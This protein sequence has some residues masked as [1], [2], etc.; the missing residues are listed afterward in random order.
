[1]STTVR[2]LLPEKL[3]DFY[4]SFSKKY[5]WY[6]T[7]LV[8]I[9][10]VSA[11]FRL[12]V[13]YELQH[14]IDSVAENPKAPMIA[15]LIYFLFHKT[16]HHVVHFLQKLLG[17]FYKPRILQDVTETVY[18]QVMRH[19]LQW[20]DVNRSGE[21]SAKIQDFQDS[22][23]GLVN[24]AFYALS[25][26]FIVAL[27]LV[28]LS[29]VSTHATVVLLVFTIIY[30]PIITFFV[31]KQMN[32]E[33]K[34]AIVRQEAFGTINDSISNVFCIKT[35]GRFSWEFDLKL[36]PIL[37]KW[38]L[39]ERKSRQYHAY[40]VDITDTILVIAMGIVQFT[41]I[42]HLYR[43]GLLTAGQFAF[44]AVVTLQLHRELSEL[45]DDVIF[46][47]NPKLAALKAAYSFIRLDSDE[48][49]VGLKSLPEIQGKI[50]YRNVYF[51]YD[52]E[53]MVL[54]NLSITIMPGEKIGIVGPSGA[55]KSTFIKSLLKYFPVSKGNIFIDDI[56]ISGI[57]QESI[58]EHIALIPQ[59]IP[60]FH[61]SILENIRIVNPNSSTEEIE[62][63]CKK[64]YIHNEIM[65]MPNQYNTIVGERGVRLSG[66]QR[67]RLA[68][69]R[70]LLKRA[71]I[72]IL[73]EATSALD[74]PTERLIQDSLN[75]I[76][77]ETSATTLMIAHRLSTL[78]KMDRVIVFQNGNIVQD[79]PHDV[80]IS[81]SNGLYKKLW[82]SQN[83]K[84]LTL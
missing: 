68:M 39:Y 67:Q 6:L 65:A 75:A 48:K 9:A 37:K 63:A 11:L 73:D 77:R 66:G 40:Y 15:L 22:L 21:I 24:G 72:L 52:H 20:F 64:A 43:N 61:R 10:L 49:E 33:N 28:F 47:C 56:P 3:S 83:T 5:F 62:S 14:I 81:D 50:E 41:L 51:G 69:A 55:G 58:C 38:S 57:R 26:I 60:F 46:L 59:D 82:D 29:T 31:K 45:I 1:M 76:I 8:I 17:V 54:K 25:R 74:S 18:A 32:A 30:T 4:R 2:A 70:A 36:I 44:V 27:S 7:G 79:G 12:E 34:C 13:D 53:N 35:M 19:S 78:S 80:L 23:L 16:M 42:A 71:P 84:G